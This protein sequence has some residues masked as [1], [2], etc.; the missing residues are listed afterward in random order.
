M[1]YRLPLLVV[2]ALLSF[3]ACQPGP[4][5]ATEALPAR[6]ITPVPEDVPGRV[7]DRIA[8]HDGVSATAIDQAQH[9]AYRR[10]RLKLADAVA[11]QGD[12]PALAFAAVLRASALRSSAPIAGKAPP[13]VDA[14]AQRWLDEAERQAPEDVTTLVFSLYFEQFDSAR[15]HALIA[16]WRKLEPRNLA[17]V[18]HA[19][20]SEPDLFDAAASTEI[21]DSHFDDVIRVTLDILSRTSSPA[22]SRLRAGATPEEH[23]SI[24]AIS[25]WAAYALPAFQ[26]VSVPCRAELMAEMRVAQCRKIAQVLMRRSDMLMAEGIGA[27]MAARL[28]TTAAERAEADAS[29]RD[30]DWLV[31]RTNEL[32]QRDIRVYAMRYVAVLLG[33]PQIT[34]RTL[35]RKLVVG[36]GF[37]PVPPSGW[38]NKK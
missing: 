28:A 17:P 18:M 26:R 11:A 13:A 35:M 23:D 38:Q 37:P 25:F 22:L 9:Q 14:T 24:L 21:F 31:A 12:A 20:L 33:T 32:S 29:R 19:S 15:R 34:E 30:A 10:D 8:S 16:R 1:T 36:A 27:V 6:A 2:F 5:P 7:A 3:V 4:S